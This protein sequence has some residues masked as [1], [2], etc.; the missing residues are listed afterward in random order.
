[1]LSPWMAGAAHGRGH[2]GGRQRRRRRAVMLHP[3]RQRIGGMLVDGRE[4]GA[5]EIA[6][7]LKEA[8]ARI[9]YHL[10]Q[11]LRGGVLKAVPNGSPSRPVYRWSQEAGWARKLLGEDDE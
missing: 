9:A 7:E 4:A 2:G 11:L 6:A 1:M 10:R 5:T 3:L 8:P